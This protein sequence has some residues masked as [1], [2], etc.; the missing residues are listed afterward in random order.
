MTSMATILAYTSPALGHMLPISA[1]LSELS[2]R[3]HAI[4]LRTFSVGVEIGQRL[5]FTTDAIDQQIEGLEHDD[6]KATNPRAAL[7]RAFAV[8][9][10]RAPHEVTDLA[11]A[12]AR[13][14]PDALLIDV[15]CW[16]G[17]SAAEAGGIPWASFSPFTPLLRADGMPPY[18]P[19]LR[20]SP[21]LFGRVR[22]AVVGTLVGGTLKGGLP[23]INKI[24]EELHLRRVGSMDE[25]WRRAP[26]MLVASGKPFEYPHAD[27]GDAV[28][29]I[30][31]CPLDPRPDTAPDWLASIDR[32]IVL[33][34][35]SSEKQGDAKLVQAAVAALVDE[36]VHVVATMPAGQPDNFAKTSNATV[37]RMIPHGVVL[38]RAVCA[39]THGGMGTTQKALARGVPV[40]VVP[41]G[42]DQFEVA[43]RVEVAGCGTRLP[44]TRLS[45]ERL[46]IKVREAMTMTDGAQ[47][48]AAGFAATGGVARGAD[49]FEQRV[50]SPHVR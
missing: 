38:D 10:R 21:N 28:Q 44:A 48:V 4:H 11:G 7:Q 27:Y 35:T 23:P 33:V 29:M 15:M 32:P 36:P 24:R 1:L 13:V 20:P 8:F 25:F 39:V 50:L 19:G 5:G 9:G 16:G 43:R 22:D 46:R 34:T 49:L 42:R 3:G 26:L 17:L 14:D 18:G 37:R 30:G 47:R 40:C 6:W 31:P 41:F 12:I 2:R 45:A